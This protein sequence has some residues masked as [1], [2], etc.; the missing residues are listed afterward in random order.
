MVKSGYKF[1]TQFFY[2]MIVFQIN[3]M[4]GLKGHQDGFQDH[5]GQLLRNKIPCQRLT[6]F[7]Q[8]GHFPVFLIQHGGFGIELVIQF[9][10]LNIGFNGFFQK[11]TL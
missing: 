11:L 5:F 8:N 4:N 3:P 2:L 10:H 9:R 7:P 1:L 6:D